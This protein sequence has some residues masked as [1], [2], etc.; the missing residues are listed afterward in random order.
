M[1]N[2]EESHASR[3]NMANSHWCLVGPSRVQWRNPIGI[4][5]Q[6][7]CWY[8]LQG[9]RFDTECKK[10]FFSLM[11]M[12]SVCLSLDCQ[13]YK[14]TRARQEG[15]CQSPRW[16]IPSRVLMVLRNQVILSITVF[17]FHKKACDSYSHLSVL[18]HSGE[19]RKDAL[20]KKTKKENFPK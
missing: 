19:N 6:L 10:G 3:K 12:R 13:V 1:R 4:L 8:G 5:L 20:Q 14:D 15:A 7:V 11:C 18:H 16:C 9:A 2:S 17:L